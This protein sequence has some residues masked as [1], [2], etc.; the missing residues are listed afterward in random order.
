MWGRGL[1]GEK[2][3]GHQ[4]MCTK[5]TWTKSKGYSF[6]GMKW[7]WFWHRDEVGGNGEN[8]T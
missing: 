3:K 1:W 8:C 2:R 7:E 4:G 6:K 5:D